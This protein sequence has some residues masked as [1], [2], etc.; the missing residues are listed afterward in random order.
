[1]KYIMGKKEIEKLHL[2]PRQLAEICNNRH[3]WM[4][5]FD[6]NWKAYYIEKNG[7]AYYFEGSGKIYCPKDYDGKNKWNCPVGGCCHLI[8]ESDWKDA[9]VGNRKNFDISYL[10]SQLKILFDEKSDIEYIINRLYC[11]LSNKIIDDEFMISIKSAKGA[12]CGV[13]CS[14][15]N[16]IYAY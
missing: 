8:S 9:A 1:M 11:Y 10:L 15:K 14:V 4:V 7:K 5:F 12:I 6:N 13:A 16:R 3:N 2:S